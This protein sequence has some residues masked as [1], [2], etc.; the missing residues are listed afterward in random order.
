MR[1]IE[2]LMHDLD[3]NIFPL[4]FDHEI[5]PSKLLSH[6]Y[7][8]RDTTILSD[9]DSIIFTTFRWIEKY[10]GNLVVDA[11]AYAINSIFVYWAS[12]AN[13]YILKTMSVAKG[14]TG[15]DT[16]RMA[17]KNEFMMPVVILTN[18]KK[19]YTSVTAQQEGMF[20]GKP[21]VDIKGVGFKGSNY[22]RPVITFVENFVG[23]TISE[24]MG[25][26]RT[27]GMK[28]IYDVI[29]MERVIYDS[30]MSG[31]TTYLGMASV[32]L[33]EEYANA[34]A[35]IYF[36]YL[37]WEAVFGETYGPI[38]LP[39]KCY[40]VPTI[41]IRNK[42]FLESYRDTFPEMYQRLIAFMQKYP[43]KVVTRIPI[44]PLTPIIPK[45]MMPMIDIRSV[46][47]N[48]TKSA[49]LFLRSFGIDL[50]S[51]K[52]PLLFSDCYQWADLNPND[53]Q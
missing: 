27:S 10:R 2:K 5:V 49:Q 28:R 33:D 15:S 7:M 11:D 19:H 9:T 52:I 45:E 20:F 4:F 6:K 21:I 40:I 38:T 53:D 48:N 35:S 25:K 36:N 43:N 1:R 46:V 32:R 31:D 29:M 13:A 12:K 41:D 14:A 51:G 22:S 42:K 3:T 39:T 23:A 50:G 24:I 44:N 47:H 26:G 34:D 8:F 37:L 17:M 18:L 16:K 30:V